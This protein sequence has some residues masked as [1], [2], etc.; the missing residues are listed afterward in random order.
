MPAFRLTY[1]R[2]DGSLEG[3]HTPA[4]ALRLDPAAFAELLA[5]MQRLWEDK[6]RQ[7]AQI[8]MFGGNDANRTTHQN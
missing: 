3:W 6:Q 7:T 8:A 2:D 4:A 1:R 5:Q